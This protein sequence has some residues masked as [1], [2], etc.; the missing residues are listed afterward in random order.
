LEL[1]KPEEVFPPYLLVKGNKTLF[2]DVQDK[3]FLLGSGTE[4]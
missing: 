3:H 1:A 2:E 4:E